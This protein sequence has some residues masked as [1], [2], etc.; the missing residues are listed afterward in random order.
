MIDRM[1]RFVITFERWVLV[2]SAVALLVV[3]I[4]GSLGLGVVVLTTS[5]ENVSRPWA[6]ATRGAEVSPVELA[7]RRKR[8]FV[9]RRQFESKM[10]DANEQI[11]ITNGDAW[12]TDREIRG[13]YRNYSRT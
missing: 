3:G 12:G 1:E 13:R 2:I 9:A 4:F 5:P 10:E 7:D 8:L 11:R 6:G